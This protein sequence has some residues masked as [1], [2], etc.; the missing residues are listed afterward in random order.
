MDTSTA[1]AFIIAGLIVVSYCANWQTRWKYRH[2]PGPPPSFPMG[3]LKTI[4]QKEVF[5]AHQ[6]WSAQYGDIC[7]VFMMRKAVIL[8]TDPAVV[9]QIATKQ[10]SRFRDR[11]MPAIDN[12]LLSGR[13]RQAAQSTMIVAKSPLWGSLRAGA[14]PMFHSEN[15]SAYAGTINKAVDELMTNLSTVAK[16]GKE[17]NIFS[18]LGQMTM[19]VTGA[20]AFGVDLQC[21]QEASKQDGMLLSAAKTVFAS[22]N[23]FNPS[24]WM[25]AA[26][27]APP[28]L[29]PLI[30]FLASVLP[31]KALLQVL[32]AFD[33]MYDVSASLIQ[34][35]KAK[36]NNTGKEPSDWLWFKRNPNNPY[37]DTTPSD[38]SI[39]P[40]LLKANTKA[41]G[42][43]LTDLQIGAQTSIIMLAGY[44]TTSV[45][46]TYCIY[47]LSKHTQVQQKLLQEVD[48]FRGQPSYEQLDHFP[49]AAAVLNEAL[50]LFPPAPL[51]ARV[52][53]QDAQIGPYAVPKGT[54]VYAGLYT[55]HRDKRW[56][57]HAEAFKPERWLGDETGG[58]K[59]GGLAYM[60]FGLGPRKCIGYKLAVEEAII[61]LVRLYQQ[62]TFEL[63]GNCQEPLDIKMGITMAPRGGM[64]VH[65]RQRVRTWNDSVSAA[66]ATA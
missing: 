57:E 44:E 11:Y 24:F 58:D 7:K 20:A 29:L 3:N 42:T 34:N 33:T 10:F 64:P 50:R 16:S 26:M 51:F 1:V 5:R 32:Q 48:D 25:V 43:P 47:L 31:G 53:H 66:Q 4:K 8:V 2:I 60:P 12:P 27:L 45:A 22:S 38:N 40:M 19:Q 39:I 28:P 18:Q 17:V 56:W 63:S 15:L 55:M 59:S 46:L 36:L 54:V 37:L 41:T 21:Q 14:Q 23:T 52:A 62:F 6:D 65:V 61:A 49:Y 35:S 13:A 30:R 9:H